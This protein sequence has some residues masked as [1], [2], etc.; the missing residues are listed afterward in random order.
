[1]DKT[2]L[3]YYFIT[4]K[5]KFTNFHLGL[6]CTSTSSRA[7]TTLWGIRSTYCRVHAAGT[8]SATSTAVWRIRSSTATVHPATASRSVLA[9][10]NGGDSSVGICTAAIRWIRT[11]C[12][13]PHCWVHPSTDSRVSTAGIHD[14]TRSTAVR[15]VRSTSLRA[16]P[17]VHASWDSSTSKKRQ[18]L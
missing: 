17:R 15:W 14:S 9:S 5:I 10:T 2:S 11:T 7:S 1:M 18:I 16:C 4:V 13:R 3:T 6:V 12:F 8:N